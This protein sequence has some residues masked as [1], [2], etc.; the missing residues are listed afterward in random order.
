MCCCQSTSIL[1]MRPQI[2]KLLQSNARYIDYV[3]TLCN[4]C[5]RVFTISECGTQR[6]NKAGEVFVECKQTQQFRGSFPIC[7][8]LCFCVLCRF[9]VCRHGFR[10]QMLHFEDVDRYAAAISSSGPLGVLRYVRMDTSGFS[11]Q[12]S[13]VFASLRNDPNL[14]SRIADLVGLPCANPQCPGIASRHLVQ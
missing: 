14:S 4:G 11:W 2:P 5:A 8:C 3:V 1:H 12:C 7:L 6:H 10:V 9:L 13:Q